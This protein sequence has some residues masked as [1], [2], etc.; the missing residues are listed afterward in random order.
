MN[1]SESKHSLPGSDSMPAFSQTFCAAGDLLCCKVN[2]TVFMGPLGSQ[3]L[4]F[5]PA[6]EGTDPRDSR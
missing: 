4:S 3:D 6:E 1:D 5:A 2:G